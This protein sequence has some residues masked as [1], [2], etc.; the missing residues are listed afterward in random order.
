MLQRDVGHGFRFCRATRTLASRRNGQAWYALERVRSE[1]STRYAGFPNALLRRSCFGLSDRPDAQDQWIAAGCQEPTCI[2]DW[3]SQ[4]T[5][6]TSITAFMI[7][8]REI[9]RTPVLTARHAR[10]TS[11]PR[12][13]ACAAPTG[14]SRNYLATKRS[15]QWIV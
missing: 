9:D 12:W 3:Q 11:A 2:G 13:K 4:Q 5:S 10:P 1:A 14:W 7:R 8:L 6:R 15:S